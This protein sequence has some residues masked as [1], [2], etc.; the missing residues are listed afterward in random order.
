MKILKR[1]TKKSVNPVLTALPQNPLASAM[2]E[3]SNEAFT[4]NLALTNKSTLNYV[5]DWFGCGGALRQRASS[6][7]TKIFLKAFAQDALMATKILFYFRDVRGGQGERATFRNI[8]KYLAVYHPEVVSKNMENIP[9]YGRYDDLYALEGTPLE[10]E[11]FQF[12]ARQLKQD[13]RNM[14][15]GEPVSLLGKWLKS[16]NT[17]SPESCRLAKLTREAL[18][19]SSKRY[20]KVLSSLRKHIDVIERKMCGKEWN[21]INF[22]NVPS[23]ASL[24]YRSAFDR[25]AHKKYKEY[26]KKVEQGSAKINAGA[27]YP[28]EI[29]RSLIRNS[30]SKEVIK[31]AD[32]QWANM[33]N[34]MGENE[35]RGLVIADVSGSMLSGVP[36]I[37]VA[38]SLA[39]Y[40]AERNVGPFKDMWLNFSSRPT[41]QRFVGNN[42]REK[43]LNM[44]KDN[45]G[46]STNLQAAFNL[47]LNSAV[48]NKVK[49]KDMPEV[50]YII[51]DMEFN[52]ACTGNDKTN[53]RVMKEKYK[54]AGYKLPRV[55]WWNVASRNDNFPIRADDNNTALVSGCSPSILK[56]LLSSK[57]FTPLGIMQETINSPRYDRVVI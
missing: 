17:S 2:M 35:H 48:K 21:E 26:L 56:Q 55:V 3:N 11:M 10:K 16:E 19:L 41:F 34:W 18:E 6:D 54:E 14:K 30:V 28:Y 13:L 22:E 42:L 20:R 5:L 7:A 45:W 38:V 31:A 52:Q 12:I 47:I 43:Y 1:K 15:K 40:F 36:N 24:I 9:F 33:P 49:E 8:I 4:E 51:S 53:F 57:N 27:V 32:L 23:K 46:G 25:H 37:L 44:D 50:L 39:L 29:F